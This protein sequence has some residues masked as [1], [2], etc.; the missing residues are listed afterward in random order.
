ML[1]PLH[2]SCS[3]QPQAMV[4]P[5]SGLSNTRPLGL[6]VLC[7]LPAAGK[8]SLARALSHGTVWDC[9]HISYDDIILEEAFMSP[10]VIPC[11]KWHRQQLLTYIEHFL[12]VLK[13]GSSLCAPAERENT[14]W[15][16]FV[17]TL[18]EQGFVSS[19]APGPEASHLQL[20]PRTCGPLYIL[21]DDNFYYQ[22]MRYEVYQL[23]RKYSL[24]FCQL[25]VDCPLES[26][27]ER[28][29][30]RDRPVAE[31][32]ILL[33]AKKI[34]I[35]NPEKNFWEK[36]SI[37]VRSEGPNWEN[38]PGV[39]DLLQL[40]L[41]DPVK[42]VQ[43]NADEKEADRLMT[44]ASVLHQADQALRKIISETMRTAKANAPAREMKALA[45][46]LSKLKSQLLEDLRHG[47]MLDQ[48]SRCRSLE[49]QDIV[50]LFQ[51]KKDRMVQEYL[52][53]QC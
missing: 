33:M 13:T 21:L 8:S 10:V 5:I 19:D 50:T 51:Q 23:A 22:S 42:E 24:G 26:C 49:A 44:A 36:N 6:C 41:D 43:D 46:E 25:F 39:N 52:A 48:M 4:G 3:R 40:A 32:T 29:R 7:G 31:G 20:K 15:Q 27:L 12:V 11:W 38:N 28:N 9:M 45:Q 47:T 1:A 34:E 18:E 35:P 17:R 16:S 30:H 2:T 37:V 53:H 14:V